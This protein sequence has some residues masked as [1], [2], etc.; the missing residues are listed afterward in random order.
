MEADS[1]VGLALR[2]ARTRDHMS[3]QAMSAR[4]AAVDL[5]LFH[6]KKK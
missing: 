2:G 6:T 3:S 4:M 5:S 1:G